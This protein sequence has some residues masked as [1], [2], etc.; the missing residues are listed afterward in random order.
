MTTSRR[1]RLLCPIARALDHVGDRWTLLIL[2]DLHA[3]PARFSDLQQGLTGIAPNLLTDRMQQLI[4]SGLVE[5]VKGDFDVSL[6]TLT[7]LGKKTQN[8]I[9]ELAMFGGNFRPDA[10]PRRP[11]NL[12]TIALPIKTAVG[13]TVS[14]D[15]SFSVQLLV[16]GEPYWLSV[17]NGDVDMQA[18]TISEPDVTMETAYEPM[19]A[20][21]EGEIPL[22]AFASEHVNLTTHTRGKD[23]ELRAVF[24]AAMG[25]LLTQRT[26]P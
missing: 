20:A 11:G 23:E 9:F 1:Y 5:K 26:D 10:Q 6:Y 17:N 7:E 21:A 16:D 25:Y 2:R 19:L 18:G 24:R 22:A 12:R 4:E 8:L 13:R 15:V 3:G 14:A